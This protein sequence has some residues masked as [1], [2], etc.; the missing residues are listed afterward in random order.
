M[1]DGK[2][3]NVIKQG[4]GFG[5]L[6]LV[7]NTRRT[8]TVRALERSSLW[9]LDRVT[10]RTAIEEINRDNYYEYAQFIESVPLLQA[11]T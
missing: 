7:H 3:K 11:L 4:T 2:R 5:E 1:I 9:G 10:F 8:A 6:A